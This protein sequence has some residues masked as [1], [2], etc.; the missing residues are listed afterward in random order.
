MA[1]THFPDGAGGYAELAI[2]GADQLTP[3][4]ASTSFVDA[5]ATPLAGGT[6]SAVLTRLALS[7][8][9]RLLVLG[10]SGGVGL[11]LL[12]LAAA[13]G[14][15]TIAVGRRAMHEQMLGLGATW[16]IDYSSEDVGRRAV[17]LA[18]GP[19]DA[20]ADLVGG[21]SLAAA[22]RAMR[23][24][25][26][27]AVIATPELDLDLLID[28]N[29]TFHGV[30]IGDDGQRTRALASFLAE[31][32][33]RP[34]ISPPAATVRGGTSASHSGG[35]APEREDR[36]RRGLA[37]RQDNPHPVTA[38]CAVARR[39]PPGH[40]RTAGPASSTMAARACNRRSGRSWDRDQGCQ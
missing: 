5:A 18:G 10:A 6:A 33:L 9:T 40:L 12:Q 11:F 28:A 21:K 39:P 19:V 22:L 24:A 31:G 38:P 3:V 35:Q 32:T 27:I 2:A 14:I 7:P 25:G 29:I 36:A 15:E 23:P 34:V 37:R 16:C 13:G 26:Q 17:S 30:L 1:M 4:S 20:I 8:G